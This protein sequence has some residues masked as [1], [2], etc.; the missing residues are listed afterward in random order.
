MER[1]HTLIVATCILCASIIQARAA[2]DTLLHID[3]AT[4]RLL[5]YHVVAND[6]DSIVTVLQL[7]EIG[8]R[9]GPS[10]SHIA[11]DV[12]TEG[13]D[14]IR[15]T[16]GTPMQ[17][18]LLPYLKSEQFI[19]ANGADSLILFR[20]I[21]AKPSRRIDGSLASTWKFDDRTM[22][23]TVVKDASTHA[24]LWTLDSVGIDA[25]TTMGTT[26][27]YIGNGTQSA[28]VARAVPGN[29][30]DRMVYVQ[31]IPYRYGASPLGMQYYS[32]HSPI[33]FSAMYNDGYRL[34]SP[35][36]ME[37]LWEK[38]FRRYMTLAEELYARHCVVP[39]F[40]GLLFT[41][42]RLDSVE[43]RFFEIDTTVRNATAYRI[44]PCDGSAQRQ[45][46]H[47]R[48]SVTPGMPTIRRCRVSNSIVY[49]DLQGG[50][51]DAMVMLEVSSEQGR[52]FVTS[53][54]GT[55]GAE[56]RLSIAVPAPSTSG[57]GTAT[58]LDASRRKLSTYPLVFK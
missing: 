4:L 47:D 54:M 53:W 23:V 36:A 39:S 21:G 27:P 29:V 58:I 6:F 49:L 57:P 48:A 42:E 40:Q 24:I 51:H 11:L 37:V 16:S 15:D 44:K 1:I 34:I 38:Q 20:Q 41:K 43:R 30:R 19:I 7:G 56:D 8:V 55:I 3:E 18:T 25:T 52:D 50:A 12:R 2:I 28:R 31:I 14:A 17:S 13:Y 26:I 22:F 46:A 32:V 10:I 33:A 5:R 45:K 35:A 9:S